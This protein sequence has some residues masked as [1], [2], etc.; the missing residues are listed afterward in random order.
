MS[1]VQPA[2]LIR[3]LL[4]GSIWRMPGS[5]KTVYLTFDD[6]P[7][8]GVT[9]QVLS[10]L[11]EVG[12]K[13][14]FFCIGNCV[15]KHPELYNKLLED[16]HAVGNHTYSHKNG[17]KVSLNNYIK[18]VEK[19]NQ[20]FKSKLFRPPY[21]KLSP[22]Q[23]LFLRK[24]YSIVMWDVLSMDYDTRLSSDICLNNVLHNV[25]NGSVITFHDS[26]K[27]WPRLKEI[28]PKILQELSNQGF[29]F[30]VIHPKV[31]ISK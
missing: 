5:G 4:P 24:S 26:L 17:W 8:P 19:C 6:G 21:G 10:M 30:S 16:N 31:L 22:R 23:F 29:T 13:A 11:A 15:E 27:A 3:K 7:T 12:A 2:I 18:D 28:L 1:L 9:E 25:R 20:I 14:T